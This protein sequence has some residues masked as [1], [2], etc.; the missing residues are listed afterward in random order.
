MAQDT[1]WTGSSLTFTAGQKNVLVN[2]GS[3]LA[4]IRPNMM[5]NSGNYNEP[6]EVDYVNTNTNTIYLVRNWAGPSGTTS[7]TVTPGFSELAALRTSVESLASGAQAIIDGAKNTATPHSIAVRTAGGALKVANASANDEAV[8]KGQLGAAAYLESYKDY[9]IGAVK[10]LASGSS[11][12]DT[13]LKN[14]NY[15]IPAAIDT[16]S[17]LTANWVISVNATNNALYRTVKAWSVGKLGSAYGEFKNTYENGVWGGWIRTD[18][19]GYGIGSN[20]IFNNFS[21]TDLNTEFLSGFGAYSSS[22]ANIPVASSFGLVM[23][24]PYI[25]TNDTAAQMVFSTSPNNRV[26]IR[27]GSVATSEWDEL[28]HSGNTNFDHLNLP[29]GRVLSHDA[30]AV[31]TDVVDCEVELDS[32]TAPTS[33]T[34]TGT[35][36]LYSTTSGATLAVNVTPSLAPTCHSKN[37]ILR[38]AVTGATV[39]VRYRAVADPGGATVKYNF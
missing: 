18:P 26:F 14:G 9:G 35:F 4:S 5:L 12:L 25:N 27:S 28:Y 6:A 39:G 38:F 21:V 17:A 23:N 36:S 8:A 11:L 33:I 13:T 15:Y 16:P 34:P 19:Q 20:G 29:A 30:I 24:L 32:V 3:A 2:T 22:A 31:T 37:G 10:A 1:F 7:A